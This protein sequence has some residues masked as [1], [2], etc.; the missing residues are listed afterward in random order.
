MPDKILSKP[1]GC[2]SQT[3]KAVGLNSENGVYFRV[4]V[5]GRIFL[6]KFYFYSHL[7]IKLIRSLA[8]LHRQKRK[9]STVV[10]SSTKFLVT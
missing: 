2:F 9:N 7:K 5:K 3:S 4:L 8:I 1:S 10:Q 6:C